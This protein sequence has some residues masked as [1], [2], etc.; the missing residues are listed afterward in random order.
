MIMICHLRYRARVQRGTAAAVGYR[1]PGAPYANWVVLL[2][3]V[4]V[5]VMLGMNADT[6]VALIVGPIWFGILGVAYAARRRAR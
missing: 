2:F 1:M 3:L 6:R 4:G 5:S